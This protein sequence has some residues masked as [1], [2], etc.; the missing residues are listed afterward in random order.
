MRFPKVPLHV[1]GFL[2]CVRRLFDMVQV[3]AGLVKNY[4]LTGIESAS[5]LEKDAMNYF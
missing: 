3:E 4:S 2:T 5:T 1:C